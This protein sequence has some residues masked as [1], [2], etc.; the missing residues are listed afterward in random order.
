MHAEKRLRY[1]RRRAALTADVRRRAAAR[2]NRS[3]RG[4]RYPARLD[5]NPHA[6]A[7]YRGPRSLLFGGGSACYSITRYFGAGG[8]MATYSD[9]PLRWTRIST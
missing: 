1:R 2:P 9:V 6:L 4:P 7:K 8:A 3:E 5:C